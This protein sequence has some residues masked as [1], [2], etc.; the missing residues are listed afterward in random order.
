MNNSIY[1]AIIYKEFHL[2]VDTFSYVIYIQQKEGRTQDQALHTPE[3][4]SQGEE[5]EPFILVY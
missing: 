2:V 5:N 3:M 1:Q 4:T